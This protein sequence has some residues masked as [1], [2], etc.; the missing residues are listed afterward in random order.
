MPL[1]EGYSLFLIRVQLRPLDEVLATSGRLELLQA[2]LRSMSGAMVHN[3]NLASVRARLLQ[4][5][6]R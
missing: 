4:V 1:G 6:E 3:K 2:S 5:N